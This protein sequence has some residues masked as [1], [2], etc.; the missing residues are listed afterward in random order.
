MR[1]S[2]YSETIPSIW[3]CMIEGR[4]FASKGHA[5]WRRKGDA[6]LSFKNS[7]YWYDIIDKLYEE[8]S[9]ICEHTRYGIYWKDRQKGKELEDQA[10]EKLLTDGTV[11]YIEI[12]K[13]PEWA[14]L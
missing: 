9:D 7:G 8:H 13:V 10:Y 1:N 6:V 11:Q 5:A 3:V 4:F 12:V 14:N 2:K